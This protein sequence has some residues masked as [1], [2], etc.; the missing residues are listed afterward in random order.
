MGKGD[1]GMGA[2]TPSI[3]NFWLRHCLTP[4]LTLNDPRCHAYRIVAFNTVIEFGTA[5]YRNA[6]IFAVGTVLA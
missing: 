3:T 1:R 5:V 6:K 2:R 4:T